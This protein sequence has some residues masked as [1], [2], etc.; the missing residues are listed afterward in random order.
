MTRVVVEGDK[1]TSTCTCCSAVTSR[2]GGLAAGLQEL[3]GRSPGAPGRRRRRSQRA[4]IDRGTTEIT[5]T[6][7]RSS[8][9]SA[10]LRGSEPKHDLLADPDLFGLGLVTDTSTSHLPRLS[11]VPLAI[12]DGAQDVL[13]HSSPRGFQAAAVTAFGTIAGSARKISATSPAPESAS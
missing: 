4:R 5:P 12:S 8:I 2:R 3:S 11:P 10:V 6:Q 7:R 9:G 1:T 13:A